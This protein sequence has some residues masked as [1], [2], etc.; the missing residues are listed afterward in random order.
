M[1][2]SPGVPV[3]YVLQVFFLRFPTAL[4]CGEIRKAHVEFCNVGSVPLCCLRV[5]STHPDF[6]T[7]GSQ[8]K[9]GSS[10]GP[11]PAADGSPYQTYS[12][13]QASLAAETLASAE[14]FGRLSGV[15]EIPIQA[16][17]LQPGESAQLPLWLRGPD[18]E[19]VHEIHFLFY[20]QAKDKGSK[21]KSV[22]HKLHF[23]QLSSP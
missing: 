12:Q 2:C 14:D 18:Q 23:L 15:V 11:A 9:A 7:F 22:F 3:F 5:A 13:S 20:Y 10:P 4:L 19:G 16:S 17:A 21:I 1:P 8:T 6:F